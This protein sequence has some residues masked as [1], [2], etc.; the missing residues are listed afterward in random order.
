VLLPVAIRNPKK[1][2]RQVFI[3]L[4]GVPLGYRVQFPHQWV[5]LD[6]LE[7]KTFNLA[8]IP[9]FDYAAYAT[10]ERKVARRADV[11]VRG[12]VAY[13]YQIPLTGGVPPTR[14]EPIGG[15]TARV[16]PKR[17]VEVFIEAFS[18][19]EKE[20]IVVVGHLAP[21][22]ANQRIRVDVTDPKQRLRV[23]LAMTD[24]SGAFRATFDLTQPPNVTVFAAAGAHEKPLTGQY[25]CVASVL[26]SPDAAEATSNTVVINI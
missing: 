4:A 13:D 5:W 25:L 9:T 24:S 23:A 7:E 19:R 3:S 14:I 11:R 17:R 6:G 2:R 21:P 20:A 12:G 26:N 18:D 16:T 8:V 22:V 15:I 10:Q 1:D